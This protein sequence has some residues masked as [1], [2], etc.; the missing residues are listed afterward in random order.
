MCVVCPVLETKLQEFL[1]EKRDAIKCIAAEFPTLIRLLPPG[2]SKGKRGWRHFEFLPEPAKL[3]PT[4]MQLEDAHGE[5]AT[6]N[7]IC[8]SVDCNVMLCAW[9]DLVLPRTTFLLLRA[10]VCGN[11]CGL[12]FDELCLAA[13]VAISQVNPSTHTAA[14]HVECERC[15]T[16][17]K[18]RSA[19]LETIAILLQSRK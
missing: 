11:K 8:S 10:V 18:E 14:G 13:T 9:D 19:L 12:C 2:T 4:A 16:L 6:D 17:L 1:A 15:E 3:D 5:A 7:F